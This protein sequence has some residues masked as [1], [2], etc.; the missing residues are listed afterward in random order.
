EQFTAAEEASQRFSESLSRISNAIGPLQ[1]VSAQLNVVSQQI[2]G[3]SR[4]PVTLNVQ[5]ALQ[6]LQQLIQAAQAAA[7]QLQ[8]ISMLSMIGP[9]PTSTPGPV[10]IA[11]GPRQMASGGLV[12]GASGIDQ[13]AA[14]LTAGEFV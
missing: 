10:P 12:T 6:A 1:Q 4:I 3:L 14:R 2:Q 5:P 13:V 8:A 11:P 9:G 7:A